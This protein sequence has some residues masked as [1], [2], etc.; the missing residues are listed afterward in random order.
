MRK[1]HEQWW[2]G[3]KNLRS[4]FLKVRLLSL[5]LGKEKGA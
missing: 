4:K 2:N 1:K 5:T 3:K